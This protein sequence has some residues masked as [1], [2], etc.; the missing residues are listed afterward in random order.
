MTS[1]SRLG[2]RRAVVA[3]V[4]GVLAVVLMPQKGQADGAIPVV[5][6]VKPS[7][8]MVGTYQP[9]RSPAFAF[10]GTGFVVGDGTTIVTNAHVLPDVLDGERKE[11]VGILV[12]QGGGQP[13]FRE[14]TRIASAPDVDLALLRI[15]GPPLPALRIGNSETVQEGQPIWITGFPIGSVLGAYAATHRGVI[16]SIV[17]I[18]IPQDRSSQLDVKLVRRLSSGPLTVFQLD[19]TAYPGN[20]GSPVYDSESGDVIGIVNMVLVKGT[21]ES[22]LASPTGI[23]YAVPSRHLREL[24][25]RAK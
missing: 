21:R 4:V 10:R 5:A 15:P 2:S 12:P 22:A 24:L 8:V 25:D 18:A 16:A 6:R 14:A 7:I 19:A 13:A 3:L 20:S 23:T 9:T 11:V 1:T 17:P